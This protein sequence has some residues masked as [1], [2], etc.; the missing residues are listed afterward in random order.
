MH[1]QN[2]AKKSA[3]FLFNRTFK[4]RYL[5]LKIKSKF[6]VKSRETGENLTEIFLIKSATLSQPAKMLKS[7]NEGAS[8][9]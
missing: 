3:S 9:C 6:N 5:T 7:N 8:F 1:S 4:E 2:T